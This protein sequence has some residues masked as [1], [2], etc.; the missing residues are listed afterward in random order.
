[1]KNGVVKVALFVVRS[2]GMLGLFG[3]LA[4]APQFRAMR[5]VEA[6]QL[7]LSSETNLFPQVA[8]EFAALMPLK[9]KWLQNH[10]PSFPA[11]FKELGGDRVES[12]PSELRLNFG[13]GHVA[14]FG[15]AFT[16]SPTNS[17]QW[18]LSWYERDGQITKKLLSSP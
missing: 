17:N 13:G 8:R 16:V 10:E 4:L 15:Y 2:V 18:T 3:F 14:Y 6:K 5:A 9:T 12:Y 7:R 1:M 11:F